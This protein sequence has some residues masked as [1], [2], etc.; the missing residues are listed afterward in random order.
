VA[1]DWELLA[2]EVEVGK[3]AAEREVATK[4]LTA[5]WDSPSLRAAAGA[6][7]D[8][9]HRQRQLFKQALTELGHPPAAPNKLA[10][11]LI[12]ELESRARPEQLS[13][14]E[15]ERELRLI[16]YDLPGLPSAPAT[17]LAALADAVESVRFAGTYNDL[18]VL[19]TRA[20]DSVA[21]E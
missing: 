13:L 20:R 7:Q 2:A 8:E 15:A 10:A 17:Q 14:D 16:A 1:V 21:H 19:L 12:A 3:I 18:L 9:P 5:G 4:M 6:D 11:R